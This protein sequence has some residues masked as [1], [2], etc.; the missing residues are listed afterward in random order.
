MSKFTQV[1][2]GIKSD[3]ENNGLRVS[4]FAQVSPENSSLQD[5]QLVLNELRVLHNNAENDLT[6]CMLGRA[7]D[8]IETL[9]GYDFI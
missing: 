3:V 8:V 4:H 2:L 1:L 6:L 5:V 9:P 7:I